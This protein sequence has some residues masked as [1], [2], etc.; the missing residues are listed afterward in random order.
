MENDAGNPTIADPSVPATSSRQ[1]AVDCPAASFDLPGSGTYH[2]ASHPGRPAVIGKTVSHYCVVDKL[3]GGGMGIVYRAEDTLLHRHVALKFLP[4]EATRDRAALERFQREARS[5][6][7]LN[8]PNICTVHEIGDHEG[9]PFIVME[10]LEGHTLKTVIEGRPIRIDRVL[11]LALGIAEALEA[12]HAKGIVHRDI[13]PANI[14]VTTSGQVKVLDFGLAKLA[15]H[16]VAAGAADMATLADA[17]LTNPGTTMGTVNYMSPEQARGEALD[18]RTDLFSFG[19]VLYEMATGRAPFEGHTSAMVFAAVL[20]QAPRPAAALN[21][22]VP[23]ELERMMIKALEK[24]PDMRYQSASELKSDLK[25]LKRDRD[26]G[27]QASSR[28]GSGPASAAAAKPAQK[29]VAVLYFENLS[30]VKDDEYFRDGMTE[31]IITELS[32]IAQLR[33]F[34][35]SE[36]IVFRNKALTA[37]EVGQQLDASFVLE[38]SIRRAGNRLRITA[39]LVE[40]RTRHSAWAERYDRELEDVFAIQ[41]EI[42]R[43]I[44]QALRI[45]LTPQE[46]KTIARKPTDNLQAYDYY[47][48]GR[49]YTRRENLDF[50]LQ[51]FDQAIR[52]DENFALAHAGVGHVCGMIFELREQ[53]PRWIE[54]GLAACERAMAID[55]HS[56]EVLAARARVYY[57]QKDYGQAVRYAQSAI[58]R[59]ADCEGAY[60]VLG[61]ALFASD[62]S[63]EAAALVDRAVEVSGDDYNTFI[64]FINALS[65]LGRAQK[66]AEMRQRMMGALE[67]QLE[68]VPEDV[69]ARILLANM[70]PSFGRNDDAVRQL[71]TAVALRPGDGNVLYN[72]ACT[73]GLMERKAEALEMF[74]KALEA[75]YGNREWA[76]RDSDLECLHQDPEFRRLCG[77]GAN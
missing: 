28:P 52:L 68:L 11:E 22:E 60:N 32:K 46:E 47:L 18:A 64:P 58:E 25:R 30:G 39:Q 27:G 63:E 36:V 61:R 37:P 14:F 26:S 44:A 62:R 55:Q 19:T 75:G 20:N 3:G 21:A 72:A 42:A 38:G 29:S 41:D 40:T 57:A 5:A 10:L 12:A 7:A 65:R 56:A 33:V 9:E 50:A 70:L 6:A 45:T 53:H 1:I 16:G 35:R 67:R 51:M 49:S 24:D 8:H 43:S 4:Q 76:A 77:L 73:Y 31:D 54:R 71:Q 23:A 59:K 48:R 17:G 74:R 34:P 69:R 66:V 13:K 2:A 15:V